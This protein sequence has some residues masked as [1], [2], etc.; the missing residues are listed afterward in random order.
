M[1]IVVCWSGGE[2]KGVV[3]MWRATQCNFNPGASSKRAPCSRAARDVMD[4]QI[5]PRHSHAARE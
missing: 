3:S 2:G 5:S 1:Y 4:K